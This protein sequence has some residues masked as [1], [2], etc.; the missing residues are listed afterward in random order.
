V[1]LQSDSGRL[2]GP[3]KHSSIPA[4]VLSR[5]TETQPSQLHLSDP[6]RFSRSGR[7]TDGTDGTH[8]RYTPHLHLG[9]ESDQTV[10]GIRSGEG[11]E[12]RFRNA[13]NTFFTHRY[14]NAIMK[15]S[16][17]QKEF[18][19]LIR[20]GIAEASVTINRSRLFDRSI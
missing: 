20:N 3:R 4:L 7:T 16:R 17:L 5:R 12:K 15:H 6:T 14:R 10:L 11:G 18:V 2:V 13:T 19:L 9:T 8:V 1:S